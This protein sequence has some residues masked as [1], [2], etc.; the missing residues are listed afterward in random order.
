MSKLHSTCNEVKQ[1]YSRLQAPRERTGGD[2]KLLLWEPD[3]VAASQGS[4][5][6]LGLN[7]LVISDCQKLVDGRRGFGRWSLEIAASIFDVAAPRIVAKACTKGKDPVEALQ[8]WSLRWVPDVVEARGEEWVHRRCGEIR[9]ERFGS[10]LTVDEI[11]Q[12]LEITQDEV[13][14][15]NLRA[16]VSKDRPPAVRKEERRGADAAY[17]RAKRIASG[18]TPHDMSIIARH[19]RG[20]FGDKPL[21]TVRRH[22]R[23]GKID[24]AQKATTPAAEHDPSNEH[25]SSATVL[26]CRVE[27]EMCPRHVS[28]EPATSLEIDQIER[29]PLPRF[30]VVVVDFTPGPAF[31]PTVVHVVPKFEDTLEALKAQAQAARDA[32][33]LDDPGFAAIAF[34]EEYQRWQWAA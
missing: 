29:E 13:L 6:K 22:I 11:A 23:E 26:T 34:E 3:K 15:F 24:P 19:A 33:A 9:L 21:T 30:N 25:F 10:F 31:E 5:R 16:M 14:G 20:E 12:D 27:D 7:N 1:A 2:T 17:Q 18:A 8:H 4:G 32:Y 28:A